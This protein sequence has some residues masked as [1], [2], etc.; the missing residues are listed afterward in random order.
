MNYCCAT[1][2]QYVGNMQ[3]ICMQYAGNMFDQDYQPSKDV[4]KFLIHHLMVRTIPMVLWLSEST[5]QKLKKLYKL[6][7]IAGKCGNLVTHVVI[8]YNPDSKYAVIKF[9]LQKKNTLHI[10][11][12]NWIIKFRKQNFRLFCK[13]KFIP[14]KGV[15]WGHL[16]S[17]YYKITIN[18]FCIISDL[19]LIFHFYWYK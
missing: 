10:S 12:K 1:C 13:P 8:F 3:V 19:W 5:L 4:I 17:S 14:L 2:S 11:T 16:F 6:A 15:F 7:W 18:W 9:K